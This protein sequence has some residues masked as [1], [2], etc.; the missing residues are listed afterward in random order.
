MNLKELRQERAITLVATGI[1]SGLLSR[2][3]NKKQGLNLR[4]ARALAAKYNV[5][6]DEI[7]AAWD[8][9]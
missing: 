5:S 6:L 4:V 1:N 2:I 9:T 7:V 8:E 3:E